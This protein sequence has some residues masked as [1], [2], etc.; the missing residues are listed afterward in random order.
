VSESEEREPIMQVQDATN[1]TRE[2]KLVRSY[3]NPVDGTKSAEFMNDEGVS[4]I[5]HV[6]NLTDQGDCTCQSWTNSYEVQ[7]VCYHMIALA[8]LSN[9]NMKRLRQ[10]RA[11]VNVQPVKIDYSTKGSLYNPSNIV[12]MSTSPDETRRPVPMR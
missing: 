3:I 4:Y 2:L 8:R 5:T 6:N 1:K 7:R 10:P 11:S 12:W 9:I